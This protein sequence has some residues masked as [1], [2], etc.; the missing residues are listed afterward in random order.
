MT[1]F[2]DEYFRE[3]FFKMGW[4]HVFSRDGINGN[5][6]QLY[7]GRSHPFVFILMNFDFKFSGPTGIFAECGSFGTKILFSFQTRS[8]EHK[9]YLQ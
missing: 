8:E 3:F 7:I 4:D 1:K 2:Y 6:N 5:L 9:I